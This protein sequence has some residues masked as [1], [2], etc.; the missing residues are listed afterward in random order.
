MA[1][2]GEMAM[3][4]GAAAGTY[5]WVARSSRVESFAWML[6]RVHYEGRAVRVADAGTGKLTRAAV[7]L[8]AEVVAIDGPGGVRIQG[9]PLMLQSHG[10][11]PGT[12]RCRC[13]EPAKI[14]GRPPLRASSRRCDR[15]L[16]AEDISGLTRFTPDIT[17]VNADALQ[18][19][20]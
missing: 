11:R 10:H 19:P 15:R 5:D 14:V 8:G 9:V 2:R 7:K 3:S 1:S 16:E 6:Q 13:I 18:S 12:S 4:F 17:R 20:G